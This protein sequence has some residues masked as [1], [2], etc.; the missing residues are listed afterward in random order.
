M[1]GMDASL[2][3]TLSLASQMAMEAFL[4][5]YGRLNHQLVSTTTTEFWDVN[6]LE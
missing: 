5:H 2:V 4:Y 3:E 6:F 1:E